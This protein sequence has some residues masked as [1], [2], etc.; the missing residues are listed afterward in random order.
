LCALPSPRP[1]QLA[2]KIAVNSTLGAGTGGLTTLLLT[3][4]LGGPADI[5][6]LLNGIIAGESLSRASPGPV[7]SPCS[8]LLR[9]AVFALLRPPLL[10]ASP[11]ACQLAS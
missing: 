10:P 2:G 6:P 11:C 4:L 7:C 1:L 8:A 3:V 5:G 9:K